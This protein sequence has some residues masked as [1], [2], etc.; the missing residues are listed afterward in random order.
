MD[1]SIKLIQ[2]IHHFMSRTFPENQMD[3]WTPG[4]YQDY[5]AIDMANRYMTDRHDMGNVNPIDI[6]AS[7]DPKGEL[8]KLMGE[9]YV[10]L[11]ENQ[12]T[13]FELVGCDGIYKYSGPILKT[14][15]NTY[16][17]KQYRNR[18]IDPIAFRTGDI[19]EAQFTFSV[20]AI[21]GKRYKM[22]LTLRSLMLLD[23]EPLRVSCCICLI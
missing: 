8:T 20:V 11:P 12:V 13:Y 23:T 4:F 22:L 5:P 2:E 18:R 6:P 14:R 16:L 3:N 7:V 21:L 17:L 19:V 10:H 15:T 1:K 9:E